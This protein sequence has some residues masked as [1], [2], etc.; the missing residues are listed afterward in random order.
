MQELLLLDPIHEVDE[1]GWPSP[2]R[3]QP[4]IDAAHRGGSEQQG[5]AGRHL[6]ELSGPAARC[7]GRSRRDAETRRPTAAAPLRGS[8]LASERLLRPSPICETEAA[9]SRAHRQPLGQ[10]VDRGSARRVAPGAPTTTASAASSGASSGTASSPSSTGARPASPWSTWRAAHGLSAGC[11]T[12][13]ASACR[14][15]CP[16][17]HPLQSLACRRM[18]DPADPRRGGRALRRLCA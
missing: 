5:R 16:A 15:G 17:A 12:R 10:R 11:A 7:R 14:P 3:L 8:R 9:A 2:D 18:T 13:S 1:S 6:T 4:G